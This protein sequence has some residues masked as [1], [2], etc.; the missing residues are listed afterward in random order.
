MPWSGEKARKLGL[1]A[2]VARTGLTGVFVEGA[3]VDA[4]AGGDVE[5]GFCRLRADSE[6]DEEDKGFHRGMEADQIARF[7]GLLKGR[8]RAEG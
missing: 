5:G 3:A 8:F 6:E 2:L 7:L 4:L 1:A